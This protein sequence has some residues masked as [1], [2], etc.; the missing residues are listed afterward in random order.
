MPRAKKDPRK[1]YKATKKV[2]DD[3]EYLCIRY[4]DLKPA[5]VRELRGELNLL[6]KDF[7]VQEEQEPQEKQVQFKDCE[8][9]SR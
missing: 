1:L 7:F 5:D 4:R 9:C 8:K 3:K 2:L 6:I